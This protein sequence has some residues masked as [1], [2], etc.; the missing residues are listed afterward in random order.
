MIKRD[1]NREQT[2]FESAKTAQK[3]AYAPHSKFQ[4]G[5]A[6]LTLDGQ[7]FSGC[8]VENV[9]FPVGTCAEQNAIG[10]MVNAGFQRIEAILIL[11]PQETALVPCGACRQRI[12]EFA[13][14]QTLVL[15]ASPS[16]IKAVY[17]CE[18]L[19]PHAF[20]TDT[21]HAT[22]SKNND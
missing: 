5:A 1:A 3:Q 12:L 14:A 4:V 8:N 15:C 7:I 6:V 13:H 22:G 16:G 20:K 2:L 9:A 21:L 11:G 18:E 10:A 19:L 17:T